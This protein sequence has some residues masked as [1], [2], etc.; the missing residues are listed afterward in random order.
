MYLLAALSASWPCCNR[1]PPDLQSRA[2]PRRCD[3]PWV[4]LF[5]KKSMTRTIYPACRDGQLDRARRFACCEP[6][7]FGIR[8]NAVKN[9]VEN[10]S[11][12]LL[13]RLH[14]AREE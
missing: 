3:D 14:L 2:K 7:A 1:Q 13:Y 9:D 8:E 12:L 6:G 10:L 5:I 4:P 11:C